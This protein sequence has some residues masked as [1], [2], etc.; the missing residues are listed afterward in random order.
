[1]V[2]LLQVYS[3]EDEAY[4]T[5]LEATT[6]LYH[7]LLQPFRD[8]RE[9]AMLR[10]QQIKVRRRSHRPSALGG[11]IKRVLDLPVAGARPRARLCVCVCWVFFVAGQPS[12][13]MRS[14]EGRTPEPTAC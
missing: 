6:Q 7:Y 9:V 5:L 14:V 11:C 3:E 13:R 8:M 1:M 12:K 4:G 2:E 10:R